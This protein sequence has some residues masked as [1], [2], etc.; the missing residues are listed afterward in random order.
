MLR[1]GRRPR[2]LL[3]R[4]APLPD[5]PP[6]GPGDRTRLAAPSLR[7]VAQRRLQRFGN[8]PV[9][10]D[11]FHL[12]FRDQ[13]QA[14][15]QDRRRQALHIIRQH[16]VAAGQKRPRPRCMQEGPATGARSPSATKRC[17]RRTSSST[18]GSS[19]WCTA[20][21]GTAAQNHGRRQQLA[22]G[23]RPGGGAVC[24]SAAASG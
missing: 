20:P 19:S 3:T 21:R 4:R 13:H 6:R 1:A 12:G 8:H 17:W 15:R 5:P 11:A 24:S 23:G 16:E 18:R 14:V 7:G 9:G 22:R 10:A 2:L